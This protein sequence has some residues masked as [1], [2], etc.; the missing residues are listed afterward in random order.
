MAVPVFAPFKSY[1]EMNLN[2]DWDM[3]NAMFLPSMFFS[4][5]LSIP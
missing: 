2:R 3:K 4:T 1:E 5:G